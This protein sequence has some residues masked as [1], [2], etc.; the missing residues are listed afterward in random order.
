MGKQEYFCTPASSHSSDYFN[1][2]AAFVTGISA[3]ELRTFCSSPLGTVWDADSPEQLK[4]P[5]EVWCLCGTSVAQAKV[6]AR[7]P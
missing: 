2:I 1:F 4:P 7:G 6:C 3:S 5:L